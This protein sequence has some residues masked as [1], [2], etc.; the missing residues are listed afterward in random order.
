M[1]KYTIVSID[2]TSFA[3]K[4]ISARYIIEDQAIIED[5]EA[6]RAI[7]LEQL[8]QLKV[9]AGKTF[10]IVHMYYYSSAA[11]EHNGLPFCRVQWIS[12]E[13]KSKPDKISHNEYMQGIYIEWDEMYKHLKL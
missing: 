11:Q 5:K 6:I 7:I 13:C 9:H 12:P 4:R 1:L 2:D 3:T 10:E 8:E